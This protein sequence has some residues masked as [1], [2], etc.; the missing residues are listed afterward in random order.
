MP[1]AFIHIPVEVYIELLRYAILAAG[2]FVTLYILVPLKTRRKQIR[3]FQLDLSPLDPAKVPAQLAATFEEA[4]RTFVS[5]GFQSAG[6]VRHGVAQTKQGGFVSV[7][8]NRA[9]AESAQV[10]GVLT[11]SRRFGIRANTLVVFRT[12]FTDGTSIATS[13]MGIATSLPLDPLMSGVRVPGTTD[14][15]L[16][17]QFHRARVRRDRGARMATLEKV[18]DAASRLR[19]EHETTHQRLVR[20]GY[21]YADQANERYVPT[22]KGAFFMTYR[23]LTPFKQIQKYIKDRRANRML[24]ELGFGSISAFR[25]V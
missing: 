23:L 20:L 14:I 10:I 17:C 8:M 1:P 15:A 22:L 3:N 18:K 24:R 7:W 2:T 16:L 11:P 4:S 25:Q 6:H 5:C 12:E 9:L 19:W 13:N 21:Y